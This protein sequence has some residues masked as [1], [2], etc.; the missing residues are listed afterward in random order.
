[1][2]R[3]SSKTWMLLVA[4]AAIALYLPTLGYDFVYDSLTQIQIDDFIHQPRHFADVLSLRVLGMNVLDFNR[5]VNLFTLMVDSLLWGK[6]RRAT[7][8][9]TCSF[10]AR[11]RLS[12]FAGCAS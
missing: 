1:M 7:G 11:W 6:T 5:P 8:S 10:T 4:L 9:R 2:L 12:Y 3:W